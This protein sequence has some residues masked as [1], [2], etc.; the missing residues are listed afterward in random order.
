MTSA[1]LGQQLTLA[2]TATTALAS[3][4]QEPLGS[5]TLFGQIPQPGLEA[6]SAPVIR[7]ANP[8][9]SAPESG[10]PFQP[11]PP[12]QTP[13]ASAAEIEPEP[14]RNHHNY[15]V[16]KADRHGSGSLKAKCRDNLAAIELLKRVEADDR[17]PTPPEK[18][19]LVRYVGWGGLPQVFDS[20]NEEWTPE[21]QR[22]ERLLTPEELESAR[23]STLNA[24][25]TAPG[26]VSAMYDALRRLGF[27]HG[28][29]LEPALG[30]GHF[31]GLMPDDMQARSRITGI[32]IDSVTARLA[33]LLYPDADIRHKPFEESVLPDGGFD[34]AIG[35]IPF[36]N[37]KPFDPRFKGWN[38]LIHDYF[39]AAALGKVRHGGLITF[40]TSKGTLDK[41]DTVLR[42]YVSQQADLVAAIRLPNDAFKKNANT[43]V[44]TDIVMLRK[45]LPGELP[46]GPAWR[47]VVETT[48]SAGETIPVNE[49]FAAHPEMMLGEMRLEGRL[50][51]RAEPTLVGNGIPLEVRLAQAVALLPSVCLPRLPTLKS[52]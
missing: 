18:R 47:N 40:I 8:D 10:E 39:F 46:S 35:N 9:T 49:Y 34:V 13:P 6:S 2:F 32:E 26:V 36:G 44:P 30:L 28:R 38:F 41:H 24:H 31:I 20:C 1:Q 37:Y 7:P 15:R 42:E 48:N 21:R 12:P 5:S 27:S 51:S 4:T 11:E 14:P 33:K 29:V 52:L 17:R 19:S 22:L 45:R 43:E 50:Y 25:Y 23:A 16:T 3:K